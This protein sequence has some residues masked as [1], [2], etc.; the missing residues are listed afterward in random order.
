LDSSDGSVAGR[1]AIQKIGYFDSIRLGLDMKYKPHFYGPYSPLL[2]ESLMD[3]IASD[4]VEEIARTTV[5]GRTLY[6]YR[7]TD[8]GKELVKQLEG[9]YRK[10]LRTMK[11]VA[12]RCNKFGNN[13]YVLS[14]AAKVHYLL[15][16]KGESMSSDEAIQT[17]KQFNWKL[18]E[19][20]IESGVQLLSSLRLASRTAS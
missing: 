3:L 18:S 5:Y 7:L 8:D 2:D 4:Y 14:Y 20:D 19:K 15:S 9:K 13:I 12:N 17:G 6:S 1:T 11:S 16:Q 10:S